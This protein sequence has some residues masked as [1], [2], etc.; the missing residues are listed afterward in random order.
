[1]YSRYSRTTLVTLTTVF[2]LSV[3][4]CS[5]STPDAPPT[6]EAAAVESTAAAAA[7]A[8]EFNDADVTF[9][10]NMIPHHQQAVEMAVIALDP[11]REATDAVKD[12][13]AR[14]QGAQDPEIE[15]MTGWLSSWGQE[16]EMD[17]M[18]HSSMDGMAGM[19]TQ[20]EMD[21]LEAAVGPDFDK[22]WLTMMIA[23]HEGAIEMSKAHEAK[24][25]N[26]DAKALAT[27]ITAGQE[28]EVV[29]MR[30]LLAG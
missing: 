23:H 3:A 21:T 11:Q 1:M 22:L 7:S 6:T 24:G 14:V 26:Q 12:L 20:Q 8:A 29:E 13:A 16:T 4:A 28:A 18:D 27:A 19:M 17:A 5:S 15:L 2:M 25:M 10:Q 30:A 9:A